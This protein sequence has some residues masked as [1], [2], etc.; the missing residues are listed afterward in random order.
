[1]GKCDPRSPHTQRYLGIIFDSSRAVFRVP[2]DN[3]FA[4]VHILL[5]EALTSYKASVTTLK[6]V[7]DKC[8]GMSVAIH[9][10]S[11]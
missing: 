10:A 2:Q 1:M 11:L 4:N 3:N 8:V 6:K 5:G 7:A 9:L